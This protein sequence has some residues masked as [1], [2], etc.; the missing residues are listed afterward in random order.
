MI[1]NMPNDIMLLDFIKFGINYLYL[2]PLVKAKIF[3]R[4]SV[5]YKAS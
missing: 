3:L 4:E 1:G 2:L 5:Y